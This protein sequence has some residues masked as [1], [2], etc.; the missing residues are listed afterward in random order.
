MSFYLVS[1]EQ[2]YTI[3]NDIDYVYYSGKLDGT[4]LR[5]DRLHDQQ[6]QHRCEGLNQALTDKQQRCHQVFKVANYREQKN[7]NPRRAE[8]TCQ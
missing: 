1:L 8:G 2:P 6:E 7:I 4:N 5:L 3:R